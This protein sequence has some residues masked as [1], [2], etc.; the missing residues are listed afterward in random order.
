MVAVHAGW[1]AGTAVEL[2]LRGTPAPGPWFSLGLGLLVAA[3]LLRWWSILSLGPG[4][5]ARGVVTSDLGVVA[6]GPYR[7]IRHPNYLAVVVELVALPLV[8]GAWVTLVVATVVNGLVLRVRIRGEERLLRE[9]PGYAE[10]L[11]SRGCLLPGIG[12]WSDA[13]S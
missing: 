12:R 10:R 1:L 6:H 7:W 2:W 9:V 8:A 3:T 11:G 5:N 4:W 13:N